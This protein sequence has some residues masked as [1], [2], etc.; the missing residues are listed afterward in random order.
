MADRIFELL[1]NQGLNYLFLGESARALQCFKATQLLFSHNPRLWLRM[2]ECCVRHYAEKDEKARADL[3][4][5]FIKVGTSQNAKTVVRAE[6][7]RQGSG[8]GELDP[9]SLQ[10]AILYLN[11][12]LALLTRGSERTDAVSPSSPP[13]SPPVAAAGDSSAFALPGTFRSPVQEGDVPVLRCHIL[14]SL[15]YAHLG[16]SNALEAFRYAEELLAMPNCPGHLKFLGHLCV[17]FRS[18]LSSRLRSVTSP[19][20]Y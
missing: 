5:S 12:A 15:A 13:G 20:R 4:G 6:T 8:S 9:L 2:A 11:N 14:A 18:R 10:T 3:P 7:S 1:Y 19:D 17:L 16:T